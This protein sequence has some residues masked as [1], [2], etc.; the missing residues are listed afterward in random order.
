MPR[1][2]PGSIGNYLNV[3][4]PAAVDITGTRMTMSAWVKPPLTGFGNQQ[5][6]CKF[7]NGLVDLQYSLQ[8]GNPGLVAFAIADGAGGADGATGVTEMRVNRWGH[9]AGIK[10]GTGAN[11]IRAYANGKLDGTA[12]SN[13]VIATDPSPFRIGTRSNDGGSNQ[14]N[15]HIAHLAIWAD[16]LTDYEI[17]LLSMGVSPLAIRS[18]TIR[19]YWP[20]NDYGT[21]GQARDL[22]PYNNTASMT[23]AVPLTTDNDAPIV[24][25]EVARRSQ[26]SVTSHLKRPGLAMR[27][28][29]PYAYRQ[30]WSKGGRFFPGT[31]GNYLSV[32][33]PSSLDFGGFEIT[34]SVW[35]RLA[36]I[37]AT[38]RAIVGK[39]NSAIN[40]RSWLLDY[41]SASTRFITSADGTAFTTTSTSALR[42]GQ[43][44][45][46]CAVQ[47]S[48]NLRVF[49]DGVMGTP[50]TPARSLFNS[51]AFFGIG[52]RG[53]N[54][55]PLNGSLT[56]MGIWDRALKPDEIEQLRQGLRPPDVVTGIRDLRAYFPL[57]DYGPAGQAQDYGSI[58]HIAGMTGTVGVFSPASIPSDIAEME[59]WAVALGGES[60]IGAVP[61][62]LES[63]GAY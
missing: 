44:Q 2:F 57:W 11:A 8:M 36:A 59:D 1:S 62:T 56:E 40:Q 42:V 45:H 30:R 14:Y 28:K 24:D 51:S 20:L 54:T 23:G 3:G 22:S 39:Y 50:G 27:V 35:V 26:I 16:V 7:G 49:V 9:I 55:V 41:D 15:G 33:D 5:V 43:W 13:L 58:R 19:G 60:V 32:P 46:V 37:D 34:V 10:D 21:S 31:V 47:D 61:L 18:Q 12:T 4:T 6:A 52:I 63:L 48:T 17:Y 38:F 25:P 29:P 53:D